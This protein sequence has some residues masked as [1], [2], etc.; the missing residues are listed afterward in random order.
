MAAEFFADR[1]T[2]AGYILNVYVLIAGTSPLLPS[3]QQ[4]AG[5]SGAY[6][7]QGRHQWQLGSLLTDL[8]LQDTH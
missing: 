6:A 4:P 5:T 8:L 2:A 7:A 3:F 1:F